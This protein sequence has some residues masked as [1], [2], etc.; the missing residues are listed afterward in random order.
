[1]LGIGIDNTKKSQ[2]IKQ[3][4]TKNNFP[5]RLIKY[6]Y[7]LGRTKE[8]CVSDKYGIAVYLKYA[9]TDPK[10]KED[11]VGELN[12]VKI[13]TDEIDDTEFQLPKGVNKMDFQQLMNELN[14]SL[15]Q[16]NTS[17]GNFNK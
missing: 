8:V 4:E 9:L 6:E 11:T 12:V 10:R 16:M 1:M 17:L 14:M 13:N 15:K 2:F 3:K 5:C 7:D